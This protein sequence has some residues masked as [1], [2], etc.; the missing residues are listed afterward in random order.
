MTDKIKDMILNPEENPPEMERA[1]EYALENPLTV[2][3]RKGKKPHIEFKVQA[4]CS[5]KKH[6]ENIKK[7]V[8]KM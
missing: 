8:E 6:I 1:I 3:I 2:A 4:D 5:Q 7:T